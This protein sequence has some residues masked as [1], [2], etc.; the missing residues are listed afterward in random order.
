MSDSLVLC[1]INGRVWPVSS[2][3]L[4]QFDVDSNQKE[5]Y[6]GDLSVVATDMQSVITEHTNLITNDNTIS[7]YNSEW[8]FTMINVIINDLTHTE[9]CVTVSFDG[10][11]NPA[12]ST[13]VATVLDDLS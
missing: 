8:L 4:H 1:A 11:R 10:M 13:D 7:I 3:R 6:E 2:V 12:A 5:Y 9:N